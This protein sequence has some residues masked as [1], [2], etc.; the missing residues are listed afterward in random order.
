MI[1]NILTNTLTGERPPTDPHQHEAY[2]HLC[3]QPRALLLL[4]MSLSKTVTVASYLHD[5]HYVDLEFKKTLIVAPD[6]VARITW[7]DEFTKWAHL[8]GTRYSLIAG[9]AKQRDAALAKD[10]DIYIIGVNNLVWLLNKYIYKRVSKASGMAYGPWLGKL[11]FTE[12]VI[13]ELTMFKTRDSERFTMLARALALSEVDYRIGMTGTFTPNG[14]I[15][16]WAQTFLIDDG[17]RLGT[18]FGE[19]VDKYFTIRGNGMIVYEYKPKP[20]A[21]NVIAHKLKDI[22]LTMAT[23]DKIELPA[24][25]L[26]DED[27]QLDP[28]DLDIYNELEREYLLEFEGGMATTIKTPADLSNKL[29]QVSSGA[30]YEDR[31]DGPKQWHELNTAKLDALDALLSQHADE[32]FIVVYQY[33]HE[34][35]R[36]KR[37]FSFARELRKGAKTKEDF[38]A[39]NRGEIRLLII[40]PAGAGHGL[41]L[42]FGGR[43]MVWF[44]VTWNLEHWE[45]TIARLLRR[46]A[47]REIF[48]HRLIARGTR[49]GKVAKRLHEKGTDQEFLQN[50]IKELRRKHGTKRN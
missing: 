49:D 6:K 25:H 1:P 15:D 46:G 39:W 11:P 14:Y 32:N 40:H 30:V 13:D 17:A 24:L 43:R 19:F 41:N 33:A 28:L 27:I 26:V 22:A 36:I 45:Q 37:R 35:E 20:N 16:A 47:L 29:L 44:S 42:Q 5:K 31:E 12:L 18:K 2:D 21:A 10:A 4:G 8:A 48:I 3:A 9:D 23:R 7:P 50:E 34:V 38:N